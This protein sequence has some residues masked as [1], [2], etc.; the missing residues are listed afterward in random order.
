[1]VPPLGTPGR[2]QIGI[3]GKDIF[4]EITIFLGQKIDKTGKILNED[5]FLEITMFLGQKFTKPEHLQ[6]CKFSLPLFD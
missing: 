4:L 1:M 6:S 3:Q 5:P 2:N